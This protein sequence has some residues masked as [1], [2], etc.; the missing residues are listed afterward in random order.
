MLYE[1]SNISK[2]SKTKNE[3][4]RNPNIAY[5]KGNRI[6]GTNYIIWRINDPKY[7]NGHKRRDA[8]LSIRLIWKEYIKQIEYL[9]KLARTIS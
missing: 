9:R 8:F 4:L 5:D 3:F 6:L 1:I 7:K 2:F